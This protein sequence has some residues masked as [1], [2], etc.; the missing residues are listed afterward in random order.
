MMSRRFENEKHLRKAFYIDCSRV[1]GVDFARN[2]M[3]PETENERMK[4]K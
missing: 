2:S 3:K 4:T 1:H